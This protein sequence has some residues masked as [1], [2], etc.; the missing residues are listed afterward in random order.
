MI[1]DKKPLPEDPTP[2]E[3]PPSYEEHSQYVAF[4]KTE[5]QRDEKALPPP[6]SLPAAAIAGPSTT[7]GPRPSPRSLASSPPL[8]Q[9]KFAKSPLYKWLPFGQAARAAQEVRQTVLSL[10]R[11][12]VTV[13]DP[14][15]ALLLLQNC[16]ETCAAH[17]LDFSLILQE[18]SV[19]RHTPIYWAIIK[20]PHEDA[21]PSGIDLVKEILS[22]ASPLSED[23]ISEIFLACLTNSDQKLFQRLRRT[24]AFAGLSGSD[25]MLLGGNVPPDDVL[26]EEVP[27]DHGAF[28]VHFCVVMFQKRMRISKRVSV[29]FIARGRM[30]RLQ[31]AEFDAA[32]SSFDANYTKGTWLVELSLMEHSPPTYIDSHLLI[33]D[34]RFPPTSPS[35]YT[36]PPTNPAADTMSSMPGKLLLSPGTESRKPKPTIELRIKTSNSQQLVPQSRSISRH[37]Q[38]FVDTLH[39]PLNKNPMG[40]SLQFDGCSY[41][42]PDGSLSG[43]LEARLAKPEAE[44]IIC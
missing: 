24:A 9:K 12:V 4:N 37:D 29:E 26:V 30:W 5:F 41:I 3:A 31:F 33:S 2:A 10:L 21:N 20:R 36:A 15:S 13:P 42:S 40:N 28:V 19:E 25:E 11:D 18:R 32:H 6:S 14:Q 27:S 34:A 35:P 17:G 16:Q 8:S 23:T 38:S 1:V 39:V 43:R 22:M 44:C 7:C